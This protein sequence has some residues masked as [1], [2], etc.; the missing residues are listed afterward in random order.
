MRE[1]YFSLK[2]SYILTFINK[3]HRV[4]VILMDFEKPITKLAAV[5]VIL[6]FLIFIVKFIG[7][8]LFILIRILA[9]IFIVAIGIWFILSII[10]NL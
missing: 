1:K 9:I 10:K 3:Y 6:L 8:F 7:I 5:I 4:G 2:K